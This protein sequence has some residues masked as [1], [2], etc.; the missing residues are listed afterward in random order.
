M[1]GP[2]SAARLLRLVS[3]KQVAWM[4]LL[5]S[6]PATRLYEY[7]LLYNDLRIFSRLNGVVLT[8]L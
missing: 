7:L 4:T 6:D 1:V 3:M 2:G 5:K 8:N